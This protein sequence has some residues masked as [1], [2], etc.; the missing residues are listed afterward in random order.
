M[1]PVPPVPPPPP[2][3]PPHGSIGDYV[4]L[5]DNHDGLQDA[6]ESG[7][8]NMKVKLYAAPAGYLGGLVAT[9]TTDATGHY[10]FD[11]VPF[12]MYMVRF[13]NPAPT[14]MEYTWWRASATTDHDSDV[15]YTNTDPLYSDQYGFTDAFSVTQSQPDVTTVDAGFYKTGSTT[16]AV[17][18]D[19]DDGDSQE[20]VQ[21]GVAT[22]YD[23]V[24]H[25]G[26]QPGANLYVY[27]AGGDL[28]QSLTVALNLSGTATANLDYL[29]TSGS[30]VVN[31]AALT[32]AP[33]QSKISLKVVAFDDGL[34]EPDETAVID[35]ANGGGYIVGNPGEKKVLIQAAV[36]QVEVKASKVKVNE[37]SNELNGFPAAYEQ[38]KKDNIA[39]Y[40]KYFGINDI[41]AAPGVWAE[42][43]LLWKLT[44][45]DYD[46]N[47]LRVTVSA[48]DFVRLY[49]DNWSIAPNQLKDYIVQTVERET[50]Y[51]DV[52]DKVITKT[53]EKYVEGFAVDAKGIAKRL[54]IHLLSDTVGD[55]KTYDTPPAGQAQGAKGFVGKSVTTVKFTTGWGR[56][57]EQL[58][59]E[60]SNG[61]EKFSTYDPAKVTWDGK[62]TTY[63]MVLEVESNQN[64]RF[65]DGSV[66][67]D[68]TGNDKG[69]KP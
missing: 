28:S 22:T 61:F 34:D 35:V 14:V 62:K 63:E 51:Y 31:P 27:R 5:D 6:N 56:Y 68:V 52:S 30:S 55:D 54:D 17:W 39:L 7:L 10:K 45:P 40:K 65:K 25:E 58:I 57:D 50:V 64:W 60:S 21:N 8:A 48:A 47:D 9:T 38:S 18:L 13:V 41:A 3:P 16:T 42:K 59:Q 2:P 15:Y 69:P 12:G 29:F 46:K 53:S 67:V 49:V 24:V 66:S 4:W 36:K 44:P 33:G 37:Y 19:T 11:N 26:D 1:P 20:V 43:D 32:F 23:A